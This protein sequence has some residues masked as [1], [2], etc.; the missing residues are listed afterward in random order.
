MEAVKASR[1][2]LD[3]IVGALVG[4]AASVLLLPSCTDPDDLE[5]LGGYIKTLDSPNVDLAYYAAKYPEAGYETLAARAESVF[6]L[7]GK[8]IAVMGGSLAANNEADAAKSLYLQLLHCSSVVT[9]ARGGMGYATADYRITDFLPLLSQHDIYVL[10]CSTNDYGTGVPVGSPT[11][12]TEADGYNESHAETQCG[13]MNKCIRAIRQAFPQATVVGYTSLPFFGSG[14]SRKDGYLEEASPQSGQD[15][16]FS[17]YV[18]KQRQVFDAANVPYFDQFACGLFDEDNYSSF[19][20]SDG[21]HLNM[22]GYFLLGCKQVA[23]F[24][25]LISSIC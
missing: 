17:Q 6:G 7:A 25:D 8:S 22:D 4:V 10:W 16:N 5:L 9:Y 3:I 12:Y 21:F 14:G 13:G 24:M 1:R 18:E 2:R 11:D 19:Y 15:I 23:F 20:I